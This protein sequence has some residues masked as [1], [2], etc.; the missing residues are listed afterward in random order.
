MLALRASSKPQELEMLAKRPQKR[1]HEAPK[2]CQ[3]ALRRPQNRPRGVHEAS[4]GP[5]ELL[6]SPRSTKIVLPS[7]RRAHFQRKSCSRQDAVHI[8]NENRAPVE[9]PCT[10]PTKIVLPSRRRAHFQRPSNERF[11]SL[12]EAPGLENSRARSFRKPLRAMVEAT[13]EEASKLCDTTSKKMLE[14]AVEAAVEDASKLL[15]SRWPRSGLAGSDFARSRS[16]TTRG[17]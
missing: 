8:S 11:S 13:V 17:Q 16:A 5:F 6:Q 2:R 12:F 10:F 9:A 14:E 3:M 7:K 1:L 15:R 4:G